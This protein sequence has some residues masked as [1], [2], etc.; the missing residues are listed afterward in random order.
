MYNSCSWRAFKWLVMPNKFTM[1]ACAEFCCR[2]K[3][4]SKIPAMHYYSR[5]VVCYFFV[6][7]RVCSVFNREIEQVNNLTWAY[8][9]QT[10][11]GIRERI[12]QRERGGVLGVGSPNRLIM[13]IYETP[14]SEEYLSHSL[15]RKWN[16]LGQQVST[17][18]IVVHSAGPQLLQKHTSLKLVSNFYLVTGIINRLALSRRILVRGSSGSEQLALEKLRTCCYST[19]KYLKIALLSCTDRLSGSQASCPWI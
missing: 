9:L 3:V 1:E 14:L 2:W 13:V 15:R 16:L 17:Q 11:N 10:G 5:K 6:R 12:G 8:N 19:L 7:L 18:N 4:H